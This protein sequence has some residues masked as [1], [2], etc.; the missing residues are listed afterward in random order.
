MIKKITFF[1]IITFIIIQFG[2]SE[3]RKKIIVTKKILK[4]FTK[5]SFDEVIFDENDLMGIIDEN[6]EII[7]RYEWFNNKSNHKLKNVK[8]FNNNKEILVTIAYSYQ[9]SGEYQIHFKNNDGKRGVINVIKDPGMF[10]TYN[11]EINYYKQG[12]DLNYFIE[13]GEEITEKTGKLY[14]NND[15]VVFYKNI[16]NS[17]K[18]RESTNIYI[19]K[20]FLANYREEAGFWVFILRMII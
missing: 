6:N 9:R 16:I 12:F 13:A 8:I 17:I 19:E 2:Y 14:Y 10:I 20:K 1:I 11:F 3:K 4:N 18:D 5:V 15:L 7:I